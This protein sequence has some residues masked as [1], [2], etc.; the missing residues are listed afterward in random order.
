MSF[1]VDTM[2]IVN[3]TFLLVLMAFALRK[4]TP[5]EWLS[6]CVAAFGI[7]MLA[8]V[9]E[10]VFLLLVSGRDD[11]GVWPKMFTL[12]FCLVN[13]M[14]LNTIWGDIKTAMSRRRSGSLGGQSVV[15]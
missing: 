5:M 12:W 15:P 10:P 6:A 4:P 7:G 14:C 2:L 13:L 1:P 11:I 8:L 9:A 3:G